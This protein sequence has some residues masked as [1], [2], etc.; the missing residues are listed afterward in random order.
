M[1]HGTF[2]GVDA[3]GLLRDLGRLAPAIERPLRLR[4]KAAIDHFLG[5]C[6]NYPPAYAQQL[7]AQLQA[8]HQSE[9]STPNLPSRVDR[10]LWSGENHDLGRC[11]A[12]IQLADWLLKEF[13]VESREIQLWGHSH[14]GNVLAL[15]T[16]LLAADAATLR[17]LFRITHPFWEHLRASQTG[18]EPWHRIYQR[19]RTADRAIISQHL[20]LVTFGTPVVYGWDEA[21][22]RTLIHFIYV[23]QHDIEAQTWDRIPGFE[24]IA[25]GQ[26]GDSVQRLAIA[27][28]DIRPTW[29]QIHARLV[30]RRLARWWHPHGLRRRLKHRWKHQSRLHQ[31]GL[32]VLVDYAIPRDQQSLLNAHG[33]YTRKDFID[34]HLTTIASLVEEELHRE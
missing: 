6:G 24:E 5:D 11:A 28:T 21:G 26:A 22:Y 8:L 4:Q 15:L 3:T 18:L 9:R 31:S 23:P 30:N 32:N 17:R 20:H 19:L 7:S 14:G 2:A 16:N 25:L 1:L 34:F 10:F 13:Q 27:G 33:V 29:L 12:A